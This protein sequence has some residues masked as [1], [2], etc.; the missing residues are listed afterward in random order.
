MTATWFQLFSLLVIVVAMAVAVAA[1]F[2]GYW[3]GRN[4]TDRP[5]RSPF[6]P[7]II[8]QGSGEDPGGDPYVEAMED[9][10][11]D[12]EDKRIDTMPSR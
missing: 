12:D 4:S 2:V 7:K 3:M 11:L 10:K 6:N 9:P 5:M 8:D 1:V